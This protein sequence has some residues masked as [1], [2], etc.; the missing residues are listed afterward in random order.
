MG[1]YGLRINT[2]MQVL[3]T[4]SNPIE[5]LYAAGDC[6]CGF[7]AN[8]YPEYIVGVAVGRTLTQGYLVGDYLAKL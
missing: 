5:G 1:V 6:S 3:D 7:F 8:N 2:K 4:N